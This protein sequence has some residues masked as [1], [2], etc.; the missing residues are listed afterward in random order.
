MYTNGNDTWWNGMWNDRGENKI[1]EAKGRQSHYLVRSFRE[2]LAH[3]F[4]CLKE[5]QRGIETGLWGSS[6]NEE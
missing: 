2:I 4:S 5:V 6:G 3:L 1:L